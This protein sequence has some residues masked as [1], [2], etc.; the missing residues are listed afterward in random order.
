[1]TRISA[2]LNTFIMLV[3]AIIT[4]VTPAWGYSDGQ[5]Y[6][7]IPQTV[8]STIVTNRYFF[9]GRW[10]V[11]KKCTEFK[12]IR[13]PYIL[14]KGPDEEICFGFGF[15][16]YSAKKSIHIRI[17]FKFPEVIKHF[18]FSVGEITYSPDH[19]TA[20]VD[21]DKVNKDRAA[22]YLHHD[23]SDPI[24]VHEI[25]VSVDGELIKNYEISIVK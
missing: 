7:V 14:K 9:T 20:F 25:I 12:I 1:M 15:G 24:G 6:N 5:S 16:Y 11:D 4:A 23:Q 22:F 21:I 3:S 19:K 2:L 13:P 18:A 17:E 8:S 10:Q